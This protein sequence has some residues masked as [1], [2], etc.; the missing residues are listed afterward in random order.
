MYQEASSSAGSLA[1]FS[2]AWFS[3]AWLSPA[4]LSPARLNLPCAVNVPS[5]RSPLHA[6]FLVC[7]LL[8]GWPL[9]VLL[10]VAVP[11]N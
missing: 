6:S 4:W 11:S 2:S 8:Y 5:L 7:H 10:S 3:P 9:L 1:S